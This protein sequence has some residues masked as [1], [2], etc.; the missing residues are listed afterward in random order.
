MSPF[1]SGG[2]D[3]KPLLPTL[4]IAR[5]GDFWNT[6]LAFGLKFDTPLEAFLFLL[7]L[8]FHAV[9]HWTSENA[10]LVG[11]VTAT[12]I[13]LVLYLTASRTKAP[14]MALDESQ[15]VV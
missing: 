12:G 7:L 10:G 1:A 3:S 9:W 2:S 5:G 4:L 8:A 14:R 11:L 15:G 6:I 13:G